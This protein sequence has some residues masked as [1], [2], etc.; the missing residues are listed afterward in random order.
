MKSSVSILN[1]YLRVL[2]MFTKVSV[3]FI[4]VE[5]LRREEESK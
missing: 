1:I 5:K 4:V 3:S 2:E